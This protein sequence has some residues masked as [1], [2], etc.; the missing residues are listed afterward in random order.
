MKRDWDLI[1]QILFKLEE[2]PDTR[3][4][5]HP[6]QFPGYDEQTVS[7]HMHLLHQAGLIEATASAHP[8]APVFCL[9][10]NLTWTGHELLDTIRGDSAWNRIAGLAKEKGLDLSFEAIKQIARHLLSSVLG[11]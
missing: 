4:V 5:V 9:A 11:S 8:N 2:K 3:S 6:N 10:R 1:R 7:Y